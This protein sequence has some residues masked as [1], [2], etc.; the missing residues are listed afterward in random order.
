[1]GLLYCEQSAKSAL[2]GQGVIVDFQFIRLKIL[3]HAERVG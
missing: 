2:A 3:S 1:M